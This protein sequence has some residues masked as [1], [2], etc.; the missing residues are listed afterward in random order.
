M[1]LI[2]SLD[3]GKTAYDDYI[4]NGMMLQLKR[5]DLGDQV[6][7]AHM[8]NRQMIAKWAFGSRC[9]KECN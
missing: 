7:E 5:L 3:A 9:R 1:G 4:K 6:E 8:R 2:E